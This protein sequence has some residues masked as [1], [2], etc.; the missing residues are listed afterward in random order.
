MDNDRYVTTFAV[1]GSMQWFTIA[2]DFDADA[3]P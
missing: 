3:S 2:Q 1:P